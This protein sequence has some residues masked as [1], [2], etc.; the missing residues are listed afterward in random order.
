MARLRCIE[1]G[2]SMARSANTGISTLVDQYGTVRGR[3]RMFDR[4]VQAGRLPTRRIPTLYR[5]WGDWVVWL[6]MAA[7]VAALAAG[8][9]RGRFPRTNT[10]P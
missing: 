1:N 4:T 6:S 5:L 9:A 10:T 2:V 8:L 7:C 3:T